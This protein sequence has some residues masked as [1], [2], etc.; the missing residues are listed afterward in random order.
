MLKK[1]LIAL[2]ILPVATLAL[3]VAATA[4][5]ID[6]AAEAA[7]STAGV[8]HSQAAA[9]ATTDDLLGTAVTLWGVTGVVGVGGMIAFGIA[10]GRVGRTRPDA[11]A[12]AAP[13]TQPSLA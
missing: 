6:H 9:T 1:T 11:I 10:V 7:A 12:I 5:A 8:S 4:V 3:P 2:A 13:G